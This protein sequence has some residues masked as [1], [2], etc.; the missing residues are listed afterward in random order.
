MS[1]DCQTCG[2]CCLTKME[3]YEGGYAHLQEHDVARLSSHYRR[4]NVINV[5]GGPGLRTKSYGDFGYACV[6][7]RGTPGVFCAC[8]IHDNKPDVCRNFEPGSES[9]LSARKEIGLDVNEA[10]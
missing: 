10:A 1:Y 7:L 8:F 2:A 9:C 5:G 6:A 3:T 4:L